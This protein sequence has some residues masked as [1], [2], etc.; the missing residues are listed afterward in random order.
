MSNSG[1]A[2][3]GSSRRHRRWFFCRPRARIRVV[4]PRALHI[5]GRRTA[6]VQAVRRRGRAGRHEEVSEW[7]SEWESARAR[8]AH[9][10]IGCTRKATDLF[11]T[12]S[13]A[14]RRSLCVGMRHHQAP[15]RLVRALTRLGSSR[16]LPL[17]R[18]RQGWQDG[19]P[20]GKGGQ[21][22]SG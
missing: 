21:I 20:S 6:Y 16:A 12:A 3:R 9:R 8:G 11:S 4:Y 15:S 14:L 10:P 1:S 13:C 7:V 2:R 17:R 5:R 22:Y 19:Q 18:R